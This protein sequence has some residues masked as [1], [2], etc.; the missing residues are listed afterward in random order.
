MLR[1]T[2]G[3]L[4]V[5]LLGSAT[6]SAATDLGGP[7]FARGPSITTLSHGGPETSP[8]VIF[9]SFPDAAITAGTAGAFSTSSTP[10]TFMGD[11]YNMVAGANSI[12]GFDVYPV[13]TSG[14]N[15]NALKINIFVWDTV[16]T[17]GTVNATT[18]A[19]SNL[20]ASYSLTTTGAFN[21]GFYYPIESAT[22]GLTPGIVLATPLLI[23]DSQVGISFNYQGSTDGGVT[24]N[25]VNNL[26][27]IITG[28]GGGA[29]FTTDPMSVGSLV[30]GLPTGG[31]YRNAG[32]PTETNGN[33]IS[34]LRSL[35][36]LTDQGVAVHVYG[37]AVAVPEPTSIAAIGLAG[38][39]LV[40]RRRRA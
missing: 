10:N 37:T 11:G 29:G 15:F 22:P 21:T 7:S 35:G 23:S 36:G 39:G 34:A 8:P 38:L 4:F 25:S 9:D 2:L 27:S 30:L 1:K 16:N 24:F 13:N 26:T 5:V 17:S 19:F 14:T 12:T 6:V 3:S 32:T 31:Y 18:P 28:L 20:L 33:F 40:A